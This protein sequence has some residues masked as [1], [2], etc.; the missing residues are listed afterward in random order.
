MESKKQKQTLPLILMQSFTGIPQRSILGSQ[1]SI[2]CDLLYDIDDLDMA[3]Y[4]D[5]N[6]T[7]TFSPDPD[8]AC[9]RLK[10]H[11]IMIFE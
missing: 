10:K 4:T 3:G 2:L 8:T 1:F 7:C 6:K 5:D 11:T 9:R